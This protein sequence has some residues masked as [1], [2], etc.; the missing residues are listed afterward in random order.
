MYGHK[1]RSAVSMEIGYNVET[2]KTWDG[3]PVGGI[4]LW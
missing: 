3:P 2:N 4:K 1:N